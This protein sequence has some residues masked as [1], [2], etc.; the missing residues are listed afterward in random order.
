MLKTLIVSSVLVFSLSACTPMSVLK[1]LN[2]FDKSGISVDAQVGKENT[3]QNA[4]IAV[5]GDQDAITESIVNKDK[6]GVVLGQ[7]KQNKVTTD[8]IET[9]VISEKQTSIKADN[10]EIKVQNNST[11]IPFWVV[12]LLILGWVLPTP[13]TMFKSI[14]K[15]RNENKK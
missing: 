12:L 15:W 9:S 10:S 7:S 14:V 5:T 13:Y 4:A 8:K 11:N 2:P 1:T 6:V 3:Q